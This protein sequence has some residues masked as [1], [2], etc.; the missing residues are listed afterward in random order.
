MRANMPSRT[1]LASRPSLRMLA[2]TRSAAF[3]AQAALS[4]VFTVVTACRNFRISRFAFQTRFSAHPKTINAETIRTKL[5]FACGALKHFIHLYGIL[6]NYTE[7]VQ[8]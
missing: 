6:R 2:E 1:L 7:G 4:T 3:A 5:L 8:C